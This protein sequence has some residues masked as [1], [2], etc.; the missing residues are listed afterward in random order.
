[1]QKLENPAYLEEREHIAEQYRIMRDFSD[2]TS[3][4]DQLEMGEYLKLELKFITGDNLL[5]SRLAQEAMNWFV[6][7]NP[8]H[9]YRVADFCGKNNFEMSPT[10][11]NIFITVSTAMLQGYPSISGTLAEIE[12]VEKKNKAMLLICNL[13]YLGETLKEASN[14]AAKNHGSMK[15]STL[16]TEYTKKFRKKNPNQLSMQDFLFASW[17]RYR[18]EKIE[19]WDELSRSLPLCDPEQEGS[20]R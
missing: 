5:A 8:F 20:R 9:V 7:K 2:E 18:E 4:Y 6:D 16:E 19:G 17:D 11:S 15:A 1:M 10:L 12:K 3:K 14:K 13:I